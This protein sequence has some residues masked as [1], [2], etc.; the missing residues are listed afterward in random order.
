ML[1]EASKAARHA[2]I[3][4]RYKRRRRGGAHVSLAALRVRDLT[5]LLWSRYGRSLPDDDAGR[6]DARI[7]VHHLGALT[8]DPRKRINGWL[9][10]AA[11]WMSLV[12]AETL[13]I[14]AITKPQHWRADKLAWRMRLTDA[15]RTALRITTIGA[16]DLSKAERTKRRKERHRLLA[17]ARRQA[18]GAKS[19]AAYLASASLGKPWV[20]LGISRSTW[21]RRKRD[22][23][24]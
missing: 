10:Q 19:R 11:P 17:R 1:G 6:D 5:N 9:R 4:R 20:A 24:A 3:E 7:M 8:G 13:L 23:G 21:R 16:I 22:Q 2:E 15:E 18:K 14:E 12:D